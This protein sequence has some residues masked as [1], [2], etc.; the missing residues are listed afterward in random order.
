MATD[1]AARGLDVERISHV[2]NYD[3]PYDI[4]TYV[5][6]IGRTG[7]AGRS[8][9]AI[10]FVS[11]RE[12]RMLRSIEKATK[13]TIEPMQLPTH[14]DIADRR[15][16]QFKG[17]ISETLDNQ[18]LSF[19]QGLIH[20]YQTEAGSSP[21]EIAAALAYLVQ[22][23][24]PL[25]PPEPK[26]TKSKK[27]RAQRR[28]NVDRNIKMQAYR[29]EVGSEIGV[30]P[31]NIVGAIA[32]ESGLE[33]G[34]I[35]DIQ[36]FDHHSTLELPEGM[37]RDVLKHLRKVKIFGEPLKISV[38]EGSAKFNGKRKRDRPRRAKSNE[39]GS[40]GPTKRKRMKKSRKKATADV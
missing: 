28:K 30:K 23:D 12:K 20:N 19:F 31:K 10:L 18:D 1:V 14:A 29:L 24:R 40:V 7:R 21:E 5:H 39:D 17:K 2:I 13:Q 33:S 11:P 15:I 38:L 35:Q 34:Y 36:I 16:A 22:L 6:R 27:D 37:P 9:D 8:G 32:N 25:L 3:I 26:E 4:E